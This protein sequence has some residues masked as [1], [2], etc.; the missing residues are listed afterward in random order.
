MGSYHR[1][2]PTY[3]TDSIQTYPEA[4]DVRPPQQQPPAPQYPQYPERSNVSNFN[5]STGVAIGRGRGRGR[6]VPSS[7]FVRQPNMTTSQTVGR[8]SNAP[9][10]SNIYD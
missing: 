7:Q 1:S 2:G 8:G 9:G 6:G 10:L 3:E 5:G 4:P